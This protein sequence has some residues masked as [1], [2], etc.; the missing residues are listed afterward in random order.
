M[1]VNNVYLFP[2]NQKILM[3]V[4]ARGSI[5]L[6]TPYNIVCSINFAFVCL[7]HE[8]QVSTMENLIVF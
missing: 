3:K 4:R 7:L 6:T 1:K 2:P 5:V 8:K